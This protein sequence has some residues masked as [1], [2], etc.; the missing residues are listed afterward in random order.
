MNLTYNA[1]ITKVEL[2]GADVAISAVVPHPTN[3]R[4]ILLN[5]STLVP[6]EEG[7]QIKVTDQIEVIINSGEKSAA[8]KNGAAKSS[9]VATP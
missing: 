1:I 2:A 3:E 6:R 4:E 5:I 7:L 8:P 9:K